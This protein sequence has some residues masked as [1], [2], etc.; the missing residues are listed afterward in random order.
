MFFY[1]KITFAAVGLAGEGL[2]TIVD[3]LVAVEGL[4]GETAEGLAAV[5]GLAT[6]GLGTEGLSTGGLLTGGLE[7]EGFGLWTGVSNSS[8][9]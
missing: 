5:T 2:V 8:S 6:G 9:G 7:T 4:V 3:G 1:Y